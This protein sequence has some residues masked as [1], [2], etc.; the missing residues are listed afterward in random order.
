MRFMLLQ[1]Y[2]EPAS[3][4]PPMNEWSP[5]DIS[6]HIEFQ[7]VPNQE[8]SDLGE[9]V[10][11]QGLAGP[12]QARFV[13]WDGAGTPVVTDGPYPESKELLAGY[14]SSTSR[15]WSGPSRSRPGPRRRRRWGVRT[16][17]HEP[18]R[19]T[20]RHQAAPKSSE[21]RDGHGPPLERATEACK[22]PLA[23]PGRRPPVWSTMRHSTRL[24]SA[25]A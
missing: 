1:N 16:R 19:R 14:R 12:A 13:V 3:G 7:Y 18:V 21:R 23:Q 15:P 9:L 2:A 17:R 25:T 10:D 20:S 24:P 6:A 22:S 5:E 4:C 11:A 8:L